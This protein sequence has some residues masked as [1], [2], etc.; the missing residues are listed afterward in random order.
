MMVKEKERIVIQ[1]DQLHLDEREEA[2][3][4]LEEA[5]LLLPPEPLPAS[6]VPISC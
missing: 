6:Y 1:P 4:I 5:G 2:I 3:R